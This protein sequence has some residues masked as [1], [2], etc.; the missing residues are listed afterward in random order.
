MGFGD[1]VCPGWD[2]IQ[3]G[4]V[5]FFGDE[6]FGAILGDEVVE[7]VFAAADGDDGDV[8]LDHALCEGAAYSG[9]GA[10]YE[11]CFMGEG[12]LV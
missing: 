6:S 7:A 3:I 9:G 10:G 4:D 11:D 8:V 12:H 1:L 5:E 2:S